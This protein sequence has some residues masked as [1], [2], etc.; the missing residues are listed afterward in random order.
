MS[1]KPEK[2]GSWLT[3]CLNGIERVGNAPTWPA[4]CWNGRWCR[5]S[6]RKSLGN[7]KIWKMSRTRLKI[8]QKRMKLLMTENTGLRTK[9]A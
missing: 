4:M 6:T 8:F 2:K 1:N 5:S 3:R 7:A 9:R